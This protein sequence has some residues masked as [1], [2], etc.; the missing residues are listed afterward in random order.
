MTT[1]EHPIQI[2]N[3]LRC[4][5]RLKVGPPPNPAARLL[6]RATKPEGLCLNCA[7]TEFL[8]NCPGV[9]ELLKN[10]RCRACGKRPSGNPFDPACKCAKPDL[11]PIGEVIGSPHVQQIFRQVMAAGMADARWEDID[12]LEVV[13]NWDLPF[14]R[15]KRKRG[16]KK[17][18]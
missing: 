14:P 3:C 7:V 6:R 17:R 4:A 12:W 8:Q 11:P 16:R 18:E 9:G 5:V 15:A 2:A 10:P 13:A 1:S